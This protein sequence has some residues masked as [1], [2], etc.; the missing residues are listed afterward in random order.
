MWTGL[1]ELHDV[2]LRTQQVC[3][4]MQLR[5]ECVRDKWPIW[6]VETRIWPAAAHSKTSRMLQGYQLH[7]RSS[8]AVAR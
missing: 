3:K 1:E 2:S 6:L 8:S 7:A 4:C 5:F